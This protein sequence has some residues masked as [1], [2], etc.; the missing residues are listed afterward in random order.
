MKFLITLLLISIIV[1]VVSASDEQTFFPCGGDEEFMIMCV[2]DSENRPIVEEHIEKSCFEFNGSIVEET[3]EDILVKTTSY[4]YTIMQDEVDL[5]CLMAQE[6]Q[7]SALINQNIDLYDGLT[8]FNEG[9]MAENIFTQSK[10]IKDG[11][12]YIDKIKDKNK[13]KVKENHYSYV[14]NIMGSGYDGL[15]LEDRIVVLEGAVNA[16]T[17]ELCDKKKN[18]YSWCS[19]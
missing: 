1:P 14:E 5:V 19:P 11:I 2:G 13:L 7:I 15:D 16:L 12:N 9:I 17:T 3:C 6:M 8:D 4:P 10:T 18:A